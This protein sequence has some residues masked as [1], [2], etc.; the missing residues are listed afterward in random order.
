MKLRVPN[1][2]VEIT[3][4]CQLALE[5]DE[6]FAQYLITLRKSVSEEQLCFAAKVNIMHIQ[7]LQDGL[8]ALVKYT[9]DNDLNQSL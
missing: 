8:N 5:W 9:E 4:G 6:M 3:N 2:V 7:I 1:V